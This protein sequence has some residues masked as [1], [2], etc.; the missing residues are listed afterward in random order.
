NLAGCA[1][2][3]LVNGA[4]ASFGNFLQKFIIANGLQDRVQGHHRVPFECALRK[5]SPTRESRTRTNSISRASRTRRKKCR[6][7]KEDGLHRGDRCERG[8]GGNQ[9]CRPPG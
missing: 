7:S 4:H 2:A 9:F 1:V 3:T 5:S 8:D 6:S